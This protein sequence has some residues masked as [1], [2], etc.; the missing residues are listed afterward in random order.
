MVEIKSNGF[1]RVFDIEELL[2]KRTLEHLRGAGL[3]AVGDWYFG[4][5]VLEAA[6]R[7]WHNKS[8]QRVSAGEESVNEAEEHEEENRMEEDRHDGAFDAVSVEDRE[9]DLL[10]QMEEVG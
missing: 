7:L 4:G 8:R 6:A 5:A 9:D 2:G 3:C 10:S 1:Y